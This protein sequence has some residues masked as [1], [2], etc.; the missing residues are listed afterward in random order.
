M[1]TG[2]K[3]MK[4]LKKLKEYRK[5]MNR[6]RRKHDSLLKKIKERDKADPNIVVMDCHK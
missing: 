2:K 6:W 1:L 5:K 3:R 4:K